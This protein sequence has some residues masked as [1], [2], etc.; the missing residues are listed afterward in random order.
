MKVLVEAY[1]CSLNRGEAAELVSI[2]AD[3]GFEVTDTVRCVD[4]AIIFTCGVI[5]TTERKMLKRISNLKQ[6]SKRVIVCGCLGSISLQKIKKVAPD[7]E[8]LG[9]AEHELVV[10]SLKRGVEKITSKKLADK[11]RN[12]I[13]NGGAVAIL[14]IATG[15]RGSC[16]YCATRFA[17]G[18][19]K[20][21]TIEEIVSRA[22]RLIGTGAVEIQMCCQDTA[23]YGEDINSN[24]NELVSPINSLAGDF[25]LRIGMMNP[26]NALRNLSSVLAAYEHEKVFK[27]L[28]LP[29]QTGSDKILTLMK[30]GHDAEDFE[31]IVSKFRK[32]YKT[33]S[34][35]TDIII[36]FPNETENDFK[37]S[38]G[39]IKK[40]RPD[41][42]NVT[43]FSARPHTLAYKMS[44]KIPGWVAKNRSRELTKLRF[45]I[46]KR[47]NEAFE[48]KIVRALATERRRPGTTFL[49]TVDYRPVVVR[50]CI[51]M[52]KW[53]KIK[54]T[55]STK[56]HLLGKIN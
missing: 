55:G 18:T 37:R 36:G 16:S 19:L 39:L 2:L 26:K 23:I 15:C 47:N 9:A 34:V 13:R 53:Y 8:I 40:V 12:F 27:F 28:H 22:K 42:V 6:I 5:E 14:P 49:R 3:A 31:A 30:R 45:E 44:G 38:L 50:K 4:T 7:A 56:T 46:S 24:L 11:S 25:M 29:V 20:S 48:G 35:S 10:D 51:P 32:K 43:R 52:G 1:G 41:I 33:G 17:R 21:R 54:I